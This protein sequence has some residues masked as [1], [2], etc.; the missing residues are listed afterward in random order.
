MTANGN[1]LTASDDWVVAHVHIDH[2][3]PN[4]FIRD[5][6]GQVFIGTPAMRFFHGQTTM[7]PN[8]ANANRRVD[9]TNTAPVGSTINT[10]RFA[11]ARAPLFN[12]PVPRGTNPQQL[13]YLGWNNPNVVFPRPPAMLTF[14]A[15]LQAWARRLYETNIFNSYG[16][17]YV[18]AQGGASINGPNDVFLIQPN[19]PQ[20]APFVIPGRL[21]SGANDPTNFNFR[22]DE[23]TQTWVWITNP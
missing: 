8:Y 22:W 19:V 2:T 9:G 5:A 10:M 23:A 13:F 7:Q 1:T 16:L 20:P 14:Q 21:G 15:A 18:F 6:A 12:C 4:L 11:N 17:S 3:N